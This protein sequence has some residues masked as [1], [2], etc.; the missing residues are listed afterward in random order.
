MTDDV[1]CPDFVLIDQSKE[2]SL[3]VLTQLADERRNKG[4]GS[5]CGSKSRNPVVCNLLIVHRSCASVF[6]LKGGNRGNPK[7]ILKGSRWCFGVRYPDLLRRFFRR[8]HSR[9]R[10]SHPN[11]ERIQV[12]QAYPF[13]RSTSGWRDNRFLF[14]GGTDQRTFGDRLQRLGQRRRERL[15]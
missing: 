14:Q 13:R 3:G 9:G 5:F 1:T 11:S 6:V 10:F 8:G 15:L 4:A 7:R 2:S 12:F